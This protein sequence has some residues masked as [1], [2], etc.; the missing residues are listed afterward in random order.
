MKTSEIKKELNSLI[1][2]G[3]KLCKA[4]RYS[5]LKKDIEDFSYFVLNFEQWYTRSVLIV[6]QIIPDRYDDFVLL[7]RNDKRKHLSSATYT[8]SDALNGSQSTQHDYGPRS[9][10]PCVLRQWNILKSCLDSFDNGVRSIQIILQADIFDSEVESA[11]HLAQNGFLR[12]A[13]A[14]CGVVIEKHLAETCKNR[15][16][17]IKKKNPSISDYNEALKDNAYDTIEWRRI[18]RLGDLRNLCDH[19]KDREPTKDDIEE[20]ISG[21]EKT[22]KTIY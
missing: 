17:I 16:I 19:K 10:L 5:S 3:E 12:A 11:K 1:E 20:L 4:L 14:I 2:T 6:K 15:G 9:A 18:Q 22:I 21:T 8:I 13:G 7:Y